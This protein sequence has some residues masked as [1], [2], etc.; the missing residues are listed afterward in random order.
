MKT[1]DTLTEDERSLLLFLEAA[2][3]ERCGRV[4]T[5]HMKEGDMMIASR[6]NSEKFVAFGRISS[7]DIG[8]FGTHW[9]VLSEAAWELAAA[10]R[11]ARA[12]RLWANRTWKTAVE[13][14]GRHES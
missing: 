5:D 11:K 4:H 1:L 12:T 8:K 13:K 10:E 7:E 2:A 6:W 14:E 3:T 9:C